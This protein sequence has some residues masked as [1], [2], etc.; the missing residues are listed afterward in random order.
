[1][2]TVSGWSACSPGVLR[3]LTLLE[4]VV[5]QRLSEPQEEL[6]GLFAGNPTRKIAQ[7]PAERLLE[8]FREVTLTV[9]TASGL[10]Q[11]HLTP[12]SSLQPQILALFGFSPAVHLGCADA[13]YDRPTFQRTVSLRFSQAP[14]VK[15]RGVQT[16]TRQ[17]L[18]AGTAGKARGETGVDEDVGSHDAF[19]QG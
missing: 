17:W 14:L 4:G 2:T 11:R 13:S 18:P 12:R 1:M 6:A 16:E 9:I 19:R 7:P 10:A 15:P 8:A 3:V 5:R